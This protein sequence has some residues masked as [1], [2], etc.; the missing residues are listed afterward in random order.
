[1]FVIPIT[2]SSCGGFYDGD[3]RL[4]LRAV[5]GALA[6]RHKAGEREHR[7]SIYKRRRTP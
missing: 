2:F 5:M 7:C 4:G 3:Y 1:M 6:A